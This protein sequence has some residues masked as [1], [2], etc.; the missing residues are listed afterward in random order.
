MTAPGG[1]TAPDGETARSTAA[2][3]LEHLPDRDLALLAGVATRLGAGRLEPGRLRVDPDL[4]ERLLSDPRTF[5]AVLG[6]AHPADIPHPADLPFPGDV[7]ALGDRRDPL[8]RASPF[9]VFALAVH[10]A[11]ADLREA[12]LVGEWAGPRR[13]LPVFDAA[14]LRNFL[15]APARRLFLAELLASYVHVAS[16]SVLVQTRRGWRRQRFSELDL[17][18]L[19]ALLDVVPA[20]ERTGVYRRLGDLALFL[21][22][23]FPDHTATRAFAPAQADRLLRLAGMARD[24]T[25]RAS[26]PRDLGAP[27][28]G[29]DL[30]ERLGSRWYRLAYETAAV[31]TAPLRVVEQIA[32]RFGQ[33]RRVLNLVTDRYLFPF[34]A[35]WFPGPH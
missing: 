7:A 31:R 21:T 18:R 19:A 20:A 32:E 24:E 26:S 13:R 5:E 30:L 22:G 23:V 12:A 4:I 17:V 15:A 27:A 34:R 1:E 16:G 29:V 9:L 25:T 10:R 6:A 8:L 33:A 14:S 28:G 3:Y 2:G 11:A 35:R